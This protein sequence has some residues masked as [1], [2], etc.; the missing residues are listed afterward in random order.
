MKIAAPGQ[1]DL[2]R[3]AQ[4][5]L[6]IRAVVPVFD[7]ADFSL[8]PVS[9]KEL[10]MLPTLPVIDA[11]QHFWDIE[12]NYLPWLRDEPP[13]AFRYG[14]Y[15]S[16]KRNYLPEDYRHDA[17]GLNLVG[18]V[19][20]ETEWD[21][22]DPVGETRW[23][24][25]VSRNSGLPSAIVAYAALHHDNAAEVL[26]QHAAF[27]LVR[28]IRHK[29]NAIAS[30]ESREKGAPG[31]MTD[32]A[33]RRGYAMLARHDLSF[34]LQTPWW[35]LEEAAE[36]NAAFPATRIILNHTGL[37]RDRSVAEL[38]NWRGAMAIFASAP[39]IAVKISGLGEPGQPWSL[40]RN[41]GI[42]LDTIE[43][44]GEDRCMFASNFPVDSLVGSMATIYAGFAQATN[45]MG[46]NV[47]AKLFSENARRIYRLDRP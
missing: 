42:I 29:P 13:I 19:F 32:P 39:N 14:D 41:R 25:E 11:H 10:I 21:R 26:A 8:A 45:A 24:H 43:I 37:P 36:L 7:A 40:E 22:R 12:R 18:S 6:T 46:I 20:V 4:I 35:H 23:V 16:L 1:L 27:S 3:F 47:Q 28:G 30:P 15:G 44:F 17:S 5:R 31:S 38:A 9:A 2:Y 34:D 33:W